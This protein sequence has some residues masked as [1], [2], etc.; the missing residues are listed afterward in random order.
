M[1]LPKEVEG[2]NETSGVPGV[3]CQWVVEVRRGSQAQAWRLQPGD[4]ISLIGEDGA[5]YNYEIEWTQLFDVATQLTP[6]VIQNDIVGSTGQES[7]T[8]ITC[9]GEFNYDTGE[10]LQRWVLR[11][12]LI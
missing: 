2:G 1:N 11:A 5:T 10:Y 7:L 3:A 9:G 12:N 8:L 4:V 6:E